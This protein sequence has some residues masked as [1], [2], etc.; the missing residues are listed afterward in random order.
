MIRW[1]KS[2]WSAGAGECVEVACLD[3]GGVGVRDSKDPEG[4]T[5]AFTRAEWA[6]FLRGVHGDEF[7]LSS[8]DGE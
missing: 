8:L 7:E 4:P 6:A 1:R 5:L 2:T 3:G